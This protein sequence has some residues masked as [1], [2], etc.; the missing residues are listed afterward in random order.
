MKAFPE[1]ILHKNCC[2]ITKLNSCTVTIINNYAKTHYARMFK[3][4]QKSR[5]RCKLKVLKKK[6]KKG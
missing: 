1:L 2:P 3:T 5:I 4:Y 6:K